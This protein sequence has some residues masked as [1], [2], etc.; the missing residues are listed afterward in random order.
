MRRRA[1]GTS[2]SW[3]TDRLR[4]VVD[5]WPT[6]SP[7]AAC[8][9]ETFR[10]RFQPSSIN[11]SVAAC[12]PVILPGGLQIRTGRTGRTDDPTGKGIPARRKFFS[13]TSTRLAAHSRIAVPPGIDL[14]IDPC[15][16]LKHNKRHRR[17]VCVAMLGNRC[18]EPALLPGVKWW[19]PR[20]ARSFP[21]GF[22]ARR[23][24]RRASG[25]VVGAG[26]M[27]SN[28]AAWWLGAARQSG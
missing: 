13:P 23:R 14:A 9:P 6:L 22:R 24:E 28:Q 26:V 16:S 11:R 21:Q 19:L 2:K 15:N 10:H 7:A 5:V 20:S 25:R 27:D 1:S 3:H 18:T 12:C 8:R 4:R 17:H